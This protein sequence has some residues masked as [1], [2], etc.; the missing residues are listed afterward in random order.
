VP[1]TTVMLE[2]EI[3]MGVEVLLSAA[4]LIEIPPPAF[5]M[6]EHDS[7]DMLTSR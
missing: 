4:V 1:P 2:K 3:E 7:K 6:K 5:A